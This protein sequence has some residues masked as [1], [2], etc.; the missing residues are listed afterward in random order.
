M[1]FFPF[2][3]FPTLLWPMT[4]D[5]L[6]A[7]WWWAILLSR[8]AAARSSATRAATP[9]RMSAANETPA[10]PENSTSAS[11]KSKA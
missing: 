9:A 4:P 1:F 6:Q 2:P 5:M 11:R 8:Q 3:V 7:R 10:A